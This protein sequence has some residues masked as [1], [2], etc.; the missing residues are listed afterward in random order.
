MNFSLAEGIYLEDSKATLRWGAKRAEAWRIGQPTGR[1]PND[2][3]RLQ[4]KEHLLGGLQFGLLAYLPDETSLDRV[5][6]WLCLN[7]NSYRANDSIFQYC[8]L[9]NHLVKEL[10]TPSI[11]PRRS[12]LYAPILTW[13][14]D[15]C[16]LQLITGERHGDFT[17]LEIMKVSHA[18]IH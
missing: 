17:T 2:D 13:Q 3:T 7:P 1:T 12:H 18:Q 4:W 14:H 9:F 5:S 6:L 16:L 8:V 11:Q 10:G 15:G